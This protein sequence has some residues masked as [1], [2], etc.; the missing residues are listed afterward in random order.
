MSINVREKKEKEKEVRKSKC[1]F[2]FFRRDII[3]LEFIIYTPK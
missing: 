3:N 2:D 1:N